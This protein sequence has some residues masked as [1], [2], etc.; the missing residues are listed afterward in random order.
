VPAA[1]T[2]RA[3][4]YRMTSQHSGYSELHRT[5]LQGLLRGVLMLIGLGIVPGV[6]GA[7]VR[8]GVA[9]ITLTAYA[10]PGVHWSGAGLEM[11]FVAAGSTAALPGMT[12]N[13]PYRIERRVSATSRVVLLSRVV[14]GVVPWDRIRAALEMSAG[15]PVV[16]DVVVTPAL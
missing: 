4:S 7:Q 9:S 13:T 3:F 16:I 2:G 6:A 11:G 8:S 10:A 12:V 5:Y 15:E 14:A 1:G